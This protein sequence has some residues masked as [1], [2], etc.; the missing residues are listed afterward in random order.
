MTE[1]EIK[2]L[3]FVIYEATDISPAQLE[4]T[5]RQINYWIDHGVIPFA[6]KQQ[7]IDGV[8]DEKINKT[9]WIRLNL[10]QAVWVCLVKELISYNVS[11]ENLKELARN[12]WQ[13]PREDKYADKVFEK[14]I[15]NR[16]KIL[17]EKTVFTLEQNLGDEMLM[18]HY[19]RTII[20]P[21]TDLLK[22]AILDEKLP[23]SMVYVP[24]NNE[25][26]FLEEGSE[27]I[28]KIGSSYL[29]HAMISIPIV[30][31]VAKVLAV[32]YGN[33]KKDLIYIT[34]IERQIR[35]I[36]V[37]KKPKYVEVAFENNH[38]KPIVITEN[39]KTREDLTRF[40]MEH[41]IERGS[42][43][44]IEIRA[45]DNYKITLVK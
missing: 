24:S 28:Q 19:F 16:K 13:K 34:D 32:D 45:T 6:E 22:S 5:S 39:H 2:E 42:K 41:K 4:V 17:S 29:M 27:L 1:N 12:I 3:G 33:T 36:I 23:H 35:D 37:F 20:N 7:S 44:L 26:T 14:L 30:P 43:L 40:F 10:A 9:K 38:I 15:Q 21:F 8:D 31:L 18:E 11:V 25:H